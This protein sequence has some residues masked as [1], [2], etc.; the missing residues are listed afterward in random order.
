MERFC[1]I[2]ALYRKVLLILIYHVFS[3]IISDNFII[4]VIVFFIQVCSKAMDTATHPGFIPRSNASL[5]ATPSNASSTLLSP[6][7]SDLHRLAISSPSMQ[8]RVAPRTVTTHH[9][10]RTT[11]GMHSKG[12]PILGERG[13]RTD[14]PAGSFRRNRLTRPCSLKGLPD[15]LVSRCSTRRSLHPCSKTLTL[16]ICRPPLILRRYHLSCRLR[17]PRMRLPN[18]LLE[19]SLQGTWVVLCHRYQVAGIRFRGCT[20]RERRV[21]PRP[22]RWGYHPLPQHGLPPHPLPI[23]QPHRQGLHRLYGQHNHPP[24]CSKLVISNHSSTCPLLHQQQ[25]PCHKSLQLGF[26]NHLHHLLRARSL[27]HPPRNKA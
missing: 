26:V 9:G 2:R 24:V 6:G 10:A 20:Q 12:R 5:L 16:P 4:A 7:G 23:A 18:S 22:G 17:P 13:P 15:H 3:I 19:D 27:Q 8:C 21:F 11:A 25:T 14:H 1:Y